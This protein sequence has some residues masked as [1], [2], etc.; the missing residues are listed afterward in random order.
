MVKKENLPEPGW[1]E[2]LYAYG[3]TDADIE[4]INVIPQHRFFIQMNEVSNKVMM[5]DIREILAE[6]NLKINKDIAEIIITQNER[7][8][9][10]ITEISK[11]IDCVSRSVSDLKDEMVL[12]KTEN[13]TVHL[14]LQE[15]LRKLTFRN[16]YWLIL[17]RL[18]ATGTVMY[19]VI[20]YAH[21]HWWGVKSLLSTLGL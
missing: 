1:K 5:A 16:N 4:A 11:G 21:E 15:G 14:Q 2:Q 12:M 19:F 10:V 7:W 6:N 20:K 9:N 8:G 3:F 17:L 18:V 13:D